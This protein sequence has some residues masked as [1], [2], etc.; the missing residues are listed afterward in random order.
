LTRD[1]RNNRPADAPCAAPGAPPPGRRAAP[2][3][4]SAAAARAPRGEGAAEAS[5]DLAGPV[6]VVTLGCPKNLV[7][8]EIMLGSLHQAGF[9]V[10][11][12]IEDAALVV[13]NT[14]AFLTLSQQESVNAILEVARLKQTGNLRNLVVAGCLPERHGESVLEEMPEVDYLLGPGTLDQ[15][16]EVARG[17]LRSELP[18]GASLGHLDRSGID[19]E[20][21]VLSGHRHTAYLKI[22]EGCDRTCTFCIIP[23][24]RGRHRSRPIEEIEAEARRLAEMGVKELTLVGQDT[25]AYGV[26]LFGRYSLDRLLERLD[27]VEGIRWI[28]LLYT[29]PQAWTDRLLDCFT[30]LEKLVPYVDIPIQ[31][32]AEPVL[33]RMRR[34]VRW[35]TTEGWL[36]KM[37]QTVP[38]MT[39]RTTVITG[40]PGETEEDF[41]FLLRALREFEFDHLGAFAYSAEEGTPAAELSDPVPEELREER[42]ER[43]LAEQRSRSLRRNRGRLG[44][45]L[46]VLCDVVEKEKGIARAR[47]QGQALEI[48]GHVRI[49][50]TPRRGGPVHSANGPRPGDF[51]RVRVR[52]AGPYDL[53]GS[54]EADSSIAEEEEERNP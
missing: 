32:A 3:A 40:F 30:R 5:S 11:S 18:R 48:D 50:L 51:F 35:K 28:R 23:Q 14:C 25:T 2:A 49:P 34:G 43:I 10:A 26:D 45:S 19:W 53:I 27:R 1:P 22:S 52:G 12:R 33:R 9:Q 13:V 16:A 8:S 46:E 24:L 15:V 21:R 6:S 7:D 41:E 39:L 36:R 44:E 42:R 37:R 47:F 20:P 4:A 17:L 54:V 29:Y 38:G 31:H